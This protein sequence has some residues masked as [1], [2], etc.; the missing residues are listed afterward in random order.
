TGETL[1]RGELAARSAV[2]AAGLCERGVRPGD[3]V[4][5]AM[6]NL[7]WWPVV[8]LGVWRA[9]AAISPVSPLWTADESARVLA[10]AVPRLAIAF[11]PFAATV[12]DALRTAG[13][14]DV[15]LAVVG[16]D[17]ADATPIEALLA[18]DAGDPYAEPDLGPS[19]LA[20]VPFSSGTGGL[21]KGVRLTHGNL[22]A[23]AAQG[24]SGFRGA[25]P[26][27]ERSVVLAGAPFFHSIGLTLMLCAPLTLG[28]AIVTIPVPQLEPVLALIGRHR[29]TH[30]TVPPQ[31]FDAFATHPLIE[32]HDLS[33]VRLLGTGGTQ[34]AAD[35]ER[36]VSE[37]LG[38]V[39]RQGYG[40]TEATCT[41][42]CPLL[43]PSTPGTAG[44]L[45]PGTEAR[46][47]DPQTGADAEQG[48][49]GELWVRGPQVM[50]GY[51]GT[52][53]ETSA[54]I[55]PDG[56]LRTGDLVAIR[57]DGQLEIRGRLKELIKVKGASVAP[58]EI[59]L[60]LRQHPA[61]RDAGVVG[62]PDAECGEVPIA[63]V[64][65]TAQAGPDELAEFVAVR[66][67][68]YKRPRE[69][70]VVDEV[71]RSPTGKVLRGALRERAAAVV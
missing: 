64:A 55:T 41:I 42:S 5:V 38:C 6:P 61:V 34:T 22:A 20:A 29:V 65:L 47:I 37:R 13:L 10:R 16:G 25:G 48:D 60:V 46:L 30:L 33:S 11:A 68:G 8:A 19:D 43:G 53:D 40:M 12:R 59:E 3:L 66:L 62:V 36:E 32:E 14:D 54:A 57:E 39:A 52:A 44:W 15:E 4:A 21:P 31:V 49:A 50:Q 58:A 56:W 27:D 69:I 7:A 17:V 1:T 35:I 24:I 23:A 26:Y 67:A 70:V 18:L 51:H 71:P 45:V 2:L 28:A 9:G 63:F